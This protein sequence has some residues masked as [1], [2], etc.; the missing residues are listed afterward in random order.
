M[1]GDSADGYDVVVVGGG[2]AGLNAALML[3]RS[4]R[5]VMV[6][7]AGSPRN[8]AADGVHG[9]LGH[10][11][12]PPAELLARGRDEVRRYGGRI[13]DGA[14]TAARR[15]GDA[16]T[17]T[18]DG[19]TEVGARRLLVT[20]GVVDELPAIPGVR[21]RWGRDVLHCPY[22]H[23]WEVRDRAVGVVATGPRSVHQA[24]LFRQLSEDVVY[25]ANE[26][27][28]EDE[29][30]A[31]L[32]AR[33]IRI[34]DGEIASVDVEGDRLTGVRIGNTV[35]GRDVLVVATRL[36]VRAGFLKGLGL[37]P[38]EHP[39]GLGEHIPVDPKG[40]TS[41]AGV[42]AAGNVTDPSAQVGSSAAA[43]ATAAAQINSDLVDEDV[44]LARAALQPTQR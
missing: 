2:P 33:D 22:C 34:L 24:L 42:W 9:L 28:L 5:S 43:G 4:R 31:K 27:P 7:D 30:A 23:G 40:R 44:E 1:S 41:V 37:E 15:D 8:D 11:G 18:V 38:A 32:R 36:V 14:V 3:G 12:T 16:F 17:V 35:V 39:S 19:R 6:V 20:T 25:F 10:D 26:K 13:V 21:E 29:E